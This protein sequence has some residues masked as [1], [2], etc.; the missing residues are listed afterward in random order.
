MCNLKPIKNNT[1]NSQGTLKTQSYLQTTILRDYHC[2]L[3]SKLSIVIDTRV[4]YHW[5]SYLGFSLVS[6][7]SLT[8]EVDLSPGSSFK[9][10]SCSLFPHQILRSALS[11]QGTKEA[12]STKLHLNINN[13]NSHKNYL[14]NSQLQQKSLM[15]RCHI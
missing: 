5:G 3:A 8:Q 15:K 13:S 12:R 7:P 10:S 2:E 1:R 11:K 9:V 14:R 4:I 6:W